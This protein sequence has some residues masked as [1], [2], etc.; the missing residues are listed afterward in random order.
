MKLCRHGNSLAFTLIELLVVIGLIAVLVGGI[1][2]AL[3]REGNRSTALQGGQGIL[4]SLISGVR[5][6]AALAQAEAGLFVDVNPQS[7]GFLRMFQIAV[8]T[9]TTASP[10]W[11][12]VG[13]NVFLPNGIFLVPRNST[14]F[15]SS[16][17]FA[18]SWPTTRYSTAFIG[19]SATLQNQPNG[20]KDP[21]Y[22][23]VCRM[24]PR[25]TIDPA[26]VGNLILAP[27]N[28]TSATTI[29][30][31]NYDFLK[32]ASLSIYGV[33]TLLNDAKAFK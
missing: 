30:F 21:V 15:S 22:Q 18:S 14:A 33:L 32:G 25:G 2:V 3:T 23:V 16:V 26:D 5:G 7:E 11:T 29:E 10:T 31:P 1:G 17:S 19:T 12:T 24:S 28:K 20:T 13:N 6:R 8:N 27:G 4:S 9:G